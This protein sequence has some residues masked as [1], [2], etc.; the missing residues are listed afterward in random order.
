MLEKIARKL[1]ISESETMRIAFMQYA[2]ELDLIKE[3]IR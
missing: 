3:K 1:G 2:K